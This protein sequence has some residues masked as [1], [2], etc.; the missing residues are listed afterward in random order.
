MV[1]VNELRDALHRLV[2]LA[3][4]VVNVQL[5]FFAQHA[6]LGVDFVER[7]GVAVFM[8]LAK[9]RLAAGKGSDHTDLDRV[10]AGA[11]QRSP[12]TNSH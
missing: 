6:A 3:L 7:D 1:L 8:G 9:S 12:N 5:D 4:I 11:G 10:L 2:G